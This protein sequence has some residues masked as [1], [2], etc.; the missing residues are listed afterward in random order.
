MKD[1][2]VK[3]SKQAEGSF[4]TDDFTNWKDATVKFANHERSDFHKACTEALST[5]VDI[6]DMLNKQAVNE[7][8]VNREYLLKV[9]STMRFLA[10]QGLL[11][12]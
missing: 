8:Q 12:Q 6:R 3:V 5:T 4:L 7:K 11:Q 9:L 1:R 2:R 10:R